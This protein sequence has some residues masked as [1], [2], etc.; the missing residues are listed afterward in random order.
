MSLK[1]A[2]KYRASHSL[3]GER[4]IIY[5]TRP[6]TRIDALMVSFDLVDYDGG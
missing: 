5:T 1:A 4:H 6:G 2:W 3:L